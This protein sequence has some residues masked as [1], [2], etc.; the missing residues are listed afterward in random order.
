MRKSQDAEGRETDF[1]Y[2]R[3]SRLTQIDHPLTLTTNFDYDGEGNKTQETNR[4]E[5]STRFAYDNLGRLTRTE[6]DENITG[7]GQALITSQTTYDDPTRTRT[8]LDARGNSTVFEMDEQSRVVKITD[9]DLNEQVFE[10]DGVNKTADVDKRLNRTAFQYD[11]LNRLTKVTDALPQE[12]VT[13]YDDAARRVTETDRRNLT[14]TTQ[15]DSL[16]RLIS[17]TRSGVILEQHEYD[18]N[19]NRVLSTDANGN[20]TEFSYDGAKPSFSSRRFPTRSYLNVV[21]YRASLR[22]QKHL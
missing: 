21:P 6:L 9:A 1:I 7:G 15:L 19:N 3:L 14:R 8:E 5:V 2:D 22:C 11:G 20:R 4:R 13:V 18:G 17:V 10:Y 16:G 12:V